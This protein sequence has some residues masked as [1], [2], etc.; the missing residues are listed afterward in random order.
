MTDPTVKKP[1]IA[2][3]WIRVLLFIPGAFIIAA[4]FSIPAAVFVLKLGI[5]TDPFQTLAQL[6]KGEWLWLVVLLEF[7]I[8]LISVWLFRTYVDR[9]NM[10]SLGLDPTGFVGESATG[11]FMG[12]GLL[13]IC[14]I[15]L[16]LSGHLT[17]TDI[18]YEPQSLFISFGL[19]VMIAFSEELVFRGYILG[20]L[21]DS[22]KNKW[23]ALVISA[24]LFA[25]YHLTHPGIDTLAFAN[26]FLA[27]VLFG[28]NYIHTRNL[29]FSMLFH[30]SWN[31]FQ[32]PL[33][34]FNVSGL[35]LSSL[36]LPDIKG[37][38]MITGGEFGL[39]GSMP[40]T[41]VTLIAVLILAWA[42]ERKY[43]AATRPA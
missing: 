28:L 41:A 8:S 20:N 16:M 32:G 26:L 42:F 9:K 2:Y 17:W 24:I 43:Q 3:G 21:L 6:L 18:V 12:P 10:T 35:H 27:G 34:G 1:W 5:G 14:A 40:D 36:L 11:L 33:M 31:F 38:E 22:F 13:G 39:E 25:C 4:L 29:W 37:D 30:L 7:L 15:V 23:I 19:L